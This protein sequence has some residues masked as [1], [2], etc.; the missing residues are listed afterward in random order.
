MGCGAS[1]PADIPKD[2]QPSK[3][4]LPRVDT[5]G[6]ATS[7]TTGGA[8]PAGKVAT[9]RLKPSGVAAEPVMLDSVSCRRRGYDNQFTHPLQAFDQDLQDR[10]PMQ[11]RRSPVPWGTMLA[12]SKSTLDGTADA[13]VAA[14]AS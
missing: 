9:P 2:V 3:I 8:G 5:V 6:A 1:A 4:E 10:L 7:A 13:A 14:A 12:E 11:L